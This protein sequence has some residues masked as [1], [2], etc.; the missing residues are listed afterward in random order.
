VAVV[1]DPLG[2]VISAATDKPTRLVS[3]EK[4]L[5]GKALDEK[6]LEQAGE[7]AVAEVRIESDMHGSA[8]YKKQ[9]LRVYL[10]RAILE[11]RKPVD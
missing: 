8:A 9:L 4:V 11:A 3:A 6:L 1:L 2:I 10:R 5:R 7:A